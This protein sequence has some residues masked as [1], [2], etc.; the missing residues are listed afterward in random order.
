MNRQHLTP[1]GGPPALPGWQ[2][3]FDVYCGRPPM[4]LATARH[5]ASERVGKAE[6]N[7]WKPDEVAGQ[8]LCG[9]FIPSV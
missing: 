9:A 6:D 8:A 7:R 4:K 5:E 1:K 3:K 2:Q